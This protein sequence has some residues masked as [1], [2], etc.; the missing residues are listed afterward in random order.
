[1]SVIHL[2]SETAEQ[3][4]SLTVN[5]SQDALNIASTL[6]QSIGRLDVSWQGGDSRNIYNRYMA[7]Q[8][9]LAARL[10]ELSSLGLAMQREIQQWIDTDNQGANNR[11][12]NPSRHPLPYL[13]FL[14]PIVGGTG[15]I[16]WFPHWILDWY[17]LLPDWLR[18]FI[19]PN[20]LIPIND[21]I[22]PIERLEPV[23]PPIRI[24]DPIDPPIRI[25]DPVFEPGIID[26]NHSP[27]GFNPEP[28]GPN[29][30]PVDPGIL[31]PIRP[32]PVTDTPPSQPGENTPPQDNSGG[33]TVPAN[34]PPQTPV[35]QPNPPTYS[36]PA[37]G[38]GS[39]YG[40]AGCSPTSVSMVLDY[41]HDQN[42]SNNTASTADLI[43]MLD[44]GD[45]TPGKGISLSNMTDELADLGYHNVTQ[46]INANIDQLK[47]QLAGG[48]VIVTTGVSISGPGSI[49]G[50]DIRSIS[51]PGNTIHAMVVTGLS[52]D[53][54]QVMV[55]DPWSGQPI[56]LSTET[57]SNMWGRGANGYY[58]I[59]P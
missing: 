49:R 5:K 56:T 18:H 47:E 29:D 13:D 59:R 9:E 52:A 24:D 51:G 10:Q 37:K 14:L 48:P 19:D 35:S 21:P 53:G 34:P 58:S 54:S 22:P 33:G 23:T 16:V 20:D 55:N 44:P 17:R 1:M 45:G 31:E 50:G 42:S 43:K 57:F 26:P 40:N 8:R 39:E 46:G 11:Q 28:I 7:T 27:V 3:C 6:Q 2:E 30:P 36:V 12:S 38:Q 41:Y 15:M 25:D 4:A 32:T